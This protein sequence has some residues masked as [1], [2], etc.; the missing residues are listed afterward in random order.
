MRRE[1]RID[2]HLLQVDG[3][4]VMCRYHGDISLAQIEAVHLI[5]EEVLREHGHAHQ[6]IDMRHLHMPSAQVRRWISQW[7]QKHTLDSV[8]NFGASY[9]IFAITKLLGHAIHLLRADKRPVVLFERDEPAALA[10]LARLQ[11]PRTQ[12]RSSQHRD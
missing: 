8:I 2:Q 1:V 9:A 6:L 10:A 11:E 3:P 4:V 12:P 5:L 7:A